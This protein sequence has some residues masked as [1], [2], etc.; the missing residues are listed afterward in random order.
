MRCHPSQQLITKQVA[1]A[2]PN[3]RDLVASQA[4]A[5]LPW[6]RLVALAWTL[7][8]LA[9]KPSD[10]HEPPPQLA[11][12]SPESVGMNGNLLNRIDSLVDAEIQIKNI[13]GCVVLIAHKGKKVFHRAYGH[14]QL[15]PE[16]KKM[17]L[18]TVFDMAS[19]TKPVAT[20]TSIMMLVERGE[21]RL[22]DKYGRYIRE[23]NQWGKKDVVIWQMLVHT[24]GFVPDSP[25]AEYEDADQIWPNLWKLGLEYEPTTKFVYS[26]V[27][28]QML[29]KLVES[30]SGQSLD[31]FTRSNIFEPLGMVDSGFLPPPGHRERSATTEQREGRW[32]RGE[33][34]DPRSYAMGGIAGHAGLFSTAEDLAIYAQMILQQ[35]EY[36][37]KRILSPRTVA[38]LLKPIEVAGHQRTLGWDSRSRYS[39]NRGE[40]MTD[41][42][43]GHGGF[44]G[45]ALWIDPGLD[46]T[47]IFLSNRV[48]PD[49]SGT[50][51]HLAGRIGSIAAAAVV[52]RASE[53]TNPIAKSLRAIRREPSHP[54]L[55]GI[56]VESRDG[57]PRLDQN[58]IGRVGL[59]TNHTGVDRAGRRTVDLMKQAANVDLKVLFSPE[60][61][62]QGIRDEKVGDSVD[63]STGL[64]IYSLYGENRKP[65]EASLAKVDTIVFDIQDIGTRFYT[66]ISTMLNAMKSAAEHGKRFLVLDRPNPLGGQLIAGPVLDEGKQSFV[67]CHPIAIQHGMTVGELA[68]MFN[69]ELELSLDLTIVPVEHWR[70]DMLWPQTNLTWINPSPNM[71]SWTEALLYPG[72]G[73]LETTNVTVGRGTDRPFEILGAPFI[74]PKDLA[75]E[76]NALELPGLQFIP[77]FVTPQ[78][79]KHSGKNCGA[80]DIVVMNANRVRAVE[81]GIHIAT[82]LKRLYPKR[83]NR[84]QLNRLLLDDA[85]LAQIE[86]G[87]KETDF[88]KIY[89]EELQEFRHRRSRW[90]IYD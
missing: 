71:R 12:A 80:V 90:L 59:I 46:L 26:D 15:Q 78:A 18:D 82:T 41:A 21:I 72:I 62:I 16:E 29:G 74:Q 52:D 67:G 81:A 24:A 76:L 22:N 34:H 87:E 43:I 44:T 39:T 66:Y 53:S 56:D 27:G 31:R 19:I 85:V 7:S 63:D 38:K 42:A 79:S 28:F 17:E 89:Q 54:V 40:L 86:K 48:H 55:P 69:A 3:L 13:P 5:C 73:I 23:F 8:L 37:G 49:G 1:A 45:T 58:K 32:M 51:N 75:Q 70:R 14:R 33:V 36:A 4:L 50:A 57:F 35:G 47:V 60:H 88:R 65:S 68:R 83:W 25:L 11:A 9:I 64:T 84:E 30:V 2:H 20:A 61:G 6:L 77:R 10:G